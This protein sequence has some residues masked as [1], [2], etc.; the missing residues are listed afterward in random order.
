MTLSTVSHSLWPGQGS[1]NETGQYTTLLS[2][3]GGS[4]SVFN[5][6]HGDDHKKVVAKLDCYFL[7]RCNVI[8]EHARFN[9]RNQGEKE[10]AEMYIMPLYRLVE[11]RNY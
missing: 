10:A 7:F 9:R 3:Q 2:W 4:N 1:R 8:L 11:H 6:H 5:Q